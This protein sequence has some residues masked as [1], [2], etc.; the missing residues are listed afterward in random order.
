[1]PY[2]IL[3]FIILALIIGYFVLLGGI[4]VFIAG[5]ALTPLLLLAL[6]AS[7]ILAAVMPVVL[8]TASRWREDR[9]RNLRTPADVRRGAVLGK[10][11]RGETA[12]YGWDP[13]WPAYFPYQA[14]RDFAF[15]SRWMWNRSRV[16]FALP[17]HWAKALWHRSTGMVRW[18]WWLPIILGMIVTL[19]IPS[20][21]FAVLV[22][23]FTSVFVAVLWLVMAAATAASRAGGSLYGIVERGRRRRE[24]RK[25]TCPNPDC[26]R[27]TYSP[28]YQCPTCSQVH[29]LLLPGPLGVL[30]RVCEC[31][32]GLPSTVSRAA[33]RRLTVVC[34]YC[35]SRLDATAGARPT[36]LVPVFGPVAA[37]KTTLFANAVRG[38][39][40]L[41]AAKSGG[42]SPV[43]QPARRFAELAES[44]GVLPKTVDASRPDV[45]VFEVSLEGREYEVQLVDAAGERFATQESTDSLTY[46]DASDSWVFVLDPLMLPEVR[47][48]L[49]EHAV[50]L[51]PTGVGTGDLASSYQSVVERI[52]A[53]TGDLKGRALAIVVTKA[54]LL[55]RVPEWSDL[56]S[57]ESVK[58]LLMET[59][60]H[61]LVKSAEFDFGKGLEFFASEASSRE[62]LDPRRDP[63][64]IVDWAV[65]RRRMK[66]RFLE[67]ENVASAKGSLNSAQEVDASAQSTVPATPVTVRG[68]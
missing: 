29:R 44:G 5:F 12:G 17:I 37:G 22:T 36:V 50:D 4:I 48:R 23:L 60:A 52:K 54:D 47:S 31:G 61:N 1:M 53:T 38:M 68:E 3:F 35:D 64:R 67:P 2:V 49:E 18:A 11:P 32:T 62:M 42:L 41:S 14:Q 16:F 13:A 15:V 24:S 65:A 25:L 57:R 56:G 28:G 40:M 55:V 10:A 9:D 58:G 45:M 59:G 46:I 63:V 43:N 6:G 39:A 21:I 30:R 27:A 26:Y 51:G 7:F 20:W 34:P 19:G 33:K 66:L 8:L